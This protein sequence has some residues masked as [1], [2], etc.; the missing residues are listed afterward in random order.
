MQSRSLSVVNLRPRP[1][2]HAQR[3][4]SSTSGMRMVGGADGDCGGGGDDGG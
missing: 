2:K 1:H 4:G 3:R